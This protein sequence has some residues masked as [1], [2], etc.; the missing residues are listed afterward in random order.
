MLAF[1]QFRPWDE[2]LGELCRRLA[3]SGGAVETGVVSC[4]VLVVISFGQIRARLW[5]PIVGLAGR[6]GGE[7]RARLFGDVATPVAKPTVSCDG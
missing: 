1:G 5:G 4:A 7:P 6:W 2:R 3:A